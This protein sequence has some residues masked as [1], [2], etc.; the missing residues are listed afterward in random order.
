M[1][2]DAGRPA[3]TAVTA[4]HWWSAPPSWLTALLA[5]VLVGLLATAAILGWRL[6]QATAAEERRAAVLQAATEHTRDF[7]TLDYRHVERDTAQVLAGA[8]GEFEQQYSSSLG[9]LRALVRQNRSVSTGEVR[10]A[11]L[12]S[13]DADSARAIV[14]ADSAVRNLAARRPQPRHYRLQLDLAKVGERWLVTRLQ[15][16]G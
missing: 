13:S 10:S 15:F 7:L 2:M 8:T 12:V 14:V 6:Q 16:V 3:D 9:Q 11:G 5:V 1:A 4:R